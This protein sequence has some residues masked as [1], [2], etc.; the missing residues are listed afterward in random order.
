MRTNRA[1]ERGAALAEASVV[2]PVIVIFYGLIIF[3]YNNITVKQESMLVTR[4]KAFQNSLR[5]CPSGGERGSGG[6]DSLVGGA[7]R[8]GG[9]Q[10]RTAVAQGNLASVI[11]GGFTS[12]T[13]IE[14]RVA[15]N[16][17]L[18]SMVR[19]NMQ[20]T[21]SYVYC[22]PESGFKGGMMDIVKTLLGMARGLVL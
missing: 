3:A 15:T 14:R 12:T 21:T 22:S 16:A 10:G 7:S 5:S 6:F 8:V 20:T 13:M 19:R 2:M 18:T 1:R 9:E 17:P 11:A 4:H